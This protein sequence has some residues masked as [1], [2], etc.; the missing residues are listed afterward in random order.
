MRPCVTRKDNTHYS[1]QAVLVEPYSREGIRHVP[2][3]ALTFEIEHQCS[4]L[5]TIYIIY[6]SV[7][8]NSCADLLKPK[9]T[10]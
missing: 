9:E 2:L 5:H 4:L 10:Q 3:T 7:R 8:R 6:D 1:R